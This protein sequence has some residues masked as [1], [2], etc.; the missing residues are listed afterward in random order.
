MEE[1]HSVLKNHEDE[2]RGEVF[3]IQKKHWVALEKGDGEKH[4]W[5]YDDKV[6]LAISNYEGASAAL[7]LA[8]DMSP[9]EYERTL[10]GKGTSKKTH[11][12]RQKFEK[13]AQKQKAAVCIVC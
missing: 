5:F 11:A 12:A 6:R 4:A 10:H 8:Q 7:Q 1:I 9:K 3:F 2:S 13:M